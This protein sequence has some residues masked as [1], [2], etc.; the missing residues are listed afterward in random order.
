LSRLEVAAR[1]ARLEMPLSRIRP[2]ELADQADSS[3]T[4]RKRLTS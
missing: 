2:R 4:L 1:V 3:E